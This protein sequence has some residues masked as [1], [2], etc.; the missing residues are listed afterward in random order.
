MTF[1]FL[2]FWSEINQIEF[3]R[4]CTFSCSVHMF[5]FTK[6]NSQHTH[7]NSVHWTAAI[8]KYR[9]LICNSYLL[10]VNGYFFACDIFLFVDHSLFNRFNS[11]NRLSSRQIFDCCSQQINEQANEYALDTIINVV[12]R[13]MHACFSS[14]LSLSFAGMIVAQTYTYHLYKPFHF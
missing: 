8:V 4:F 12:D 6:Y 9:L 7:I 1:C 13:F 2:F 11:S 3:D 5:A 10:Y 14:F